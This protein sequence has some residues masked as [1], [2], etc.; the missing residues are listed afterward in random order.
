MPYWGFQTIS[1]MGDTAPSIALEGL[2][3]AMERVRTLN[4]DPLQIRPAFVALTEGTWWV[5]ALD[6]HMVKRLGK[7]QS[8]K[9]QAARDDDENGKYIR[10]F[11]WAR[12]RHTHQL[13]VSMDRDNTW[14]FGST[15]S[16][17]HIS[18]G[19]RWLPS[20]DLFEPTDPKYQRPEWRAVYEELFEGKSAW[21][22]LARASR[23]FHQMAGHPAV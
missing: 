23:W 3:A 17:I 11:L 18:P 19:F 15:T 8:K 9:Y 13:P 16:V 20:A 5:A 10:G 7:E 1:V 6:E 22:T 14:L 21:K 12:D 2:D 4:E